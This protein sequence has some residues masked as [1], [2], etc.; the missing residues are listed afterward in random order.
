MEHW[1]MCRN[2][3]CLRWV[4]AVGYVTHE[5]SGDRDLVKGGCG[6]HENN[7]GYNLPGELR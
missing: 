6:T 1:D 4:C 3:C 7:A 2:D 5:V